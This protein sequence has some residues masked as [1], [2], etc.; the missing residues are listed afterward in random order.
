MY[1][2]R[3]YL[4]L[5]MKYFYKITQYQQKQIL[6]HKFISNNKTGEYQLTL[7]VMLTL[8]PCSRNTLT[9]STRPYCAAT[10]NGVFPFYKT[11]TK[12]IM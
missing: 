2:T 6:S 12:L 11:R 1:I 3:G 10:C 4:K 9:A 7:L 8:A 5:Q